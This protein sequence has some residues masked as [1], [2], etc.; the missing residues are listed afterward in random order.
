LEKSVPSFGTDL[1]RDIEKFIT[2]MRAWMR[3]NLDWSFE[4]GRYQ[5]TEEIEALLA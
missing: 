4:S 1:D 2:V 3:G 5:P